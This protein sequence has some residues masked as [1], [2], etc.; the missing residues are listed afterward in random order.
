MAHTIRLYKKPNALNFSLNPIPLGFYV[1]NFNNNN[2]A[3]RHRVHITILFSTDIGQNLFKEIWSGIVGP[4]ASGFAEMDISPLLD[5]QLSYFTPNVNIVKVHTC[6]GQCGQFKIRYFLIDNEAQ[7]SQEYSSPV[8]NVYKG[9]V[10]KEDIDN[11]ATYL[12]T[13]KGHR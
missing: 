13:Y 10:A 12:N 11:N 6:N 4:D 5:A 9:G 7:L 1:S 2:V 3:A 8:Y